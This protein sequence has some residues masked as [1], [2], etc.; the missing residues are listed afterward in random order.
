MKIVK[1]HTITKAEDVSIIP[2]LEYYYSG[3][4]QD[5]TFMSVA[6]DVNK[7]P[8]YY[9]SS[10]NTLIEVKEI[11]DRLSNQKHA[12]WNRIVSKLQK[13]VDTNNLLSQV[14]G[15]FLVN[16]P[17]IFKTPTEQQ[18][19]ITASTDILKSV[20]SNEKTIKIFGV[21]FEINKVSDQENIVVFGTYGGGWVDTSNTVY[22]N[23]KD[24][25]ISADK[26]LAYRPTE[27]SPSK[28]IVLLSNKYYMPL[29]NWDLFKAAARTYEDLLTYNNIDEIWYQFETKEKGFTH[30]LLYKKSFFEKFENSQFNNLNAD[31]LR[32]FANWFSA[33]SEMGEEKKQKLFIAL[34]QFL[35]DKK[36]HEI[37]ENEQT[38]ED[39]VR[40]GLWLAE[41]E[42]FDELVWFIEKFITDPNPPDP[43]FYKP[44]EK[45]NYDKKI[46][47]NEDVNVI[48]TVLGHLAWDI[49]K[50]AI[51]KN[52]IIKAFEFTKILLAHSNLY[53]KL[54]GLIPLIEIAARRQW[55]QNHDQSEKSKI[56]NDFRLSVFTLLKNYS[57]YKPFANWLTRVFYYFKDLNTEEAL[58]VLDNLRNAQD[59]AALYVYFGIYRKNHFKD[60]VGF[61]PEPLVNK[62]KEV[63]LEEDE[64]NVNLQGSI[65]WHFWKIL[66]ETPDQF[67]VLKPY[68]D[69]FFT[70]PY[71]KRYY[72]SLG[73]IIEKWIESKPDICIGWF[74][75][76][77]SKLSDYGTDKK[78]EVYHIWIDPAKSLEII[79]QNDSIK[80]TNIVNV[81]VKLWELG[82]YIGSPNAIFGTYKCISNLEEKI[83]VKNQFK[84][85]YE[86][87]KLMNPKLETS[88]WE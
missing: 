80:L 11:H 77:I 23:I 84:I 70:L 3:S 24:K 1:Q 48:T 55:L 8:D 54:Q 83:R 7:R 81:L 32:L 86:K 25:L 18:A 4:R 28:K 38:R 26:Q 82:A 12:Q 85:L 58:L 62:L 73:R 59:V 52:Y 87:M 17:E 31:D 43:K 15:T 67:S 50:L 30:E 2:F 60:K 20:I 29:W 33:L 37:F 36:P 19:F 64:A 46:R 71:N 22:Q 14:K 63:I 75:I 34:Q 56:Y 69:L 27:T 10:A 16:T 45:F 39:I 76:M 88:S 42:K 44:D 40:F 66:E 57:Q 74:E 51:R 13:A 61:Y 72:S 35:K 6:E 65:A 5:I 21:E 53:V 68:L 78:D 41:K 79:A 49:Q 9:V 47:N